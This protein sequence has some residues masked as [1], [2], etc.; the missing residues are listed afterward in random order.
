MFIVVAP[1]LRRI[2][3]ARNGKKTSRFLRAKNVEQKQ[4][5][6]FNRNPVLV[7]SYGKS[8]LVLSV[9]INPCTV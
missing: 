6:N 8:F 1:V 9:A 4:D 2:T 5:W 3:G 7:L